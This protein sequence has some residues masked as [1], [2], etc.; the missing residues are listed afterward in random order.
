[1]VDRNVMRAALA[2]K[3]LAQWQLAKK[4]GFEPSTF[5]DYVRGARPAPDGFTQRVARE[6]GIDHK[7]LAVE[8]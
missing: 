8:P 2:S 6:L 7:R 4:L 5:S 1:M 3:G